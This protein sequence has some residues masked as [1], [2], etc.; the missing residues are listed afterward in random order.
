MAPSFLKSKSETPWDRFSHAMNRALQSAGAEFARRHERGLALGS[1][2]KIAEAGGDTIR[3][4]IEVKGGPREYAVAYLH[5]RDAASAP[6]AAKL[7]TLA[8]E[9]ARIAEPFGATPP[10]KPGQAVLSYP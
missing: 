5:V 6:D 8:Q 9:A 3:V 1:P 10:E 7:R 2:V 4:P